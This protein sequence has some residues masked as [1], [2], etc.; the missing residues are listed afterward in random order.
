MHCASFRTA[1]LL[2]PFQGIKLVSTQKIGESYQSFRAKE[3]ARAAQY[4]TGLLA[5]G[6]PTNNPEVKARAAG[7]LPP[8][9]FNHP[10][11]LDLA[12]SNGTVLIGSDAH[13]WPGTLTTAFRAFIEFSHSAD[14]AILN[15]DVIDGAVISRWPV[16]GW[17]DR[18]SPAEEIIAAQLAVGAI[19]A[20]IRRIW[21]FGNHDWRLESYIAQH[22]PA[23]KGLKGVHLKDWFPD[24]E[25]CWR[26]RINGNVNIKHRSPGANPLLRGRK[27]G[28]SI[29]TGHLHS[30]NVVRWTDY[31]GDHFSVDTGTL[32]RIPGERHVPQFTGYT[33]DNPVDWASGFIILTFYNSRL[34][35]PE[36]VHVIDEE[37]GKVSWRGLVYDV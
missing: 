16:N 36:V 20:K 11:R 31:S 23:L 8:I 15:G 35:W 7:K 4:R 19:N 26:V 29:I 34:L 14:F 13:I 10:Q 17:E 33:E 3:N 2:L 30:L 37:A 21:T 12:I 5:R 6:Q 24:W 1:I 22:A 32:A 25:P 9:G 28:Q 18:P 27:A